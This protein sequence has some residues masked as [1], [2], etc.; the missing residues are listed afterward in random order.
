[1]VAYSHWMNGMSCARFYP[2]LL[3][4]GYQVCMQT[5]LLPCLPIKPR[6]HQEGRK[7]ISTRKNISNALSH[8]YLEEQK[9]LGSH[10]PVSP[11]LRRWR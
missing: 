3:M 2:P 7:Q 9:Q 11:V 10:E 8:K 6:L 5:P 1:V 4:W